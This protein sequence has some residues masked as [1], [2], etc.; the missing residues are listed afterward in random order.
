MK[1][2]KVWVIVL[3][4]V[5]SISIFIFR[6]KLVTLQGYGFL[7]LFV[8]NILGSAT[9]FL[10]T[11]LFLT[12]F[13]AGSIYNPI[14]VAVVASAGSAI[15]ELTG[16]LAGYGAEDILEKDPKV[17]RIRGWMKKRGFLTLF[18]LAAIPNPIFDMAGFVAGATEVSVKKYLIA[19]WLG[20]LI[21]FSAIAYAGASSLAFLGV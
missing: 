6:D 14:L 2:S 18:L 16:Y 1:H 12:A 5:L 13:V 8:L 4:I 15:G 21:K 19:V 9:I 3:A 7:G 11:P 17:Q 10:P 20:K